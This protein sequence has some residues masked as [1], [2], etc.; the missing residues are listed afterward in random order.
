MEG[1]EVN[2]ETLATD[3][4]REVGPVPGH[5]LSKPHTR[6]WWR[7]EQF[8]PECADRLTYPVWIESGKKSCIDYAKERTEQIIKTHTS[9]PLTASQEADVEKVLEEAREYYWKKELMTA[10][11]MSAY[12]ESMKS[13][14]YPYE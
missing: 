2:H 10:E 12:K 11:E 7:H 5:F 13:A 9:I 1:V 8:V 3:L 14:N 4:I 6:E